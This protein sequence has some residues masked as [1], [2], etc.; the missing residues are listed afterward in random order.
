MTEVTALYR[1]GTLVG[2]DAAGHAGH[3]FKGTDIVCSAVSALTQ[4][5]V[6]GIVDLLLCPCSIETKDGALR[7]VV[8]EDASPE[9]IEKAELILETMLLGLRSIEEQYKKNLKLDKKEV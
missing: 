2:F 3:G 5:A 7:I 6:M 4:T 9:L 8:G 1:R